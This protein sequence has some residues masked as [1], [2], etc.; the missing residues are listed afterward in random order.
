MAENKSDGFFTALS[1][2][3]LFLFIGA[4]AGPSTIAAKAQDS[5]AEKVFI[6]LF[7][8]SFW[9]GAGFL[10]AYLLWK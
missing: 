7:I 10:T 5:T 9:F 3:F 6:W 1:I 8:R 2:L 4:F